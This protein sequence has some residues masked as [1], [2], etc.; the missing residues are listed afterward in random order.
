MRG[1]SIALLML[2]LGCGLVAAIGITQVLAKRDVGTSKDSVAMQPVVVASRDIAMGQA[3]NAGDVKV[4]S[5]PQGKAPQ[6]TLTKAE[7]ATGHIARGMIIAGEAIVDKKLRANDFYSGGIPMGYRVVSVKVDSVSSSSGLILPGDRVDVIVFFTKNPCQGILETKTQ[8]VLQDIRVFAVNADVESD[9]E[10]E[11]GGKGAIEAN[12][13]SLLV[14]PKQ[15]AKLTLASELGRL[16]LAMRSPIDNLRA[17]QTSATPIELSEAGIGNRK[18]EEPV[19]SKTNPPEKGSILDILE[20]MK[21]K[22]NNKT[23]VATAP[24]LPNTWIIR[25]IQ[26]DNVNEIVLEEDRKAPKTFAGGKWRVSDVG[27]VTS[28]VGSEK[29]GKPSVPAPNPVAAPL[30]L[31]PAPP[32]E[33]KSNSNPEPKEPPAP[34]DTPIVS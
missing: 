2:A 15:A 22:G 5:W 6:G 28:T 3:I 13:I 10:K 4:E 24:E 14:T 31:P 23:A 18:K 25:Y 7:E 33:P 8:T 27:T 9:K 26:P 20:D 16:R 1:K 34:T 12:T 17:E 19:C 32:A 29:K 21:A 11:K 30:P